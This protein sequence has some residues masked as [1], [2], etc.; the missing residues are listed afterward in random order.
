ML[1]YKVLPQY[2][3]FK[4]PDDGIYIKHE[5][6][7]ANEIA[8]QKLNVKFMKIIEISKREI[9]WFFGVRKQKN[10]RFYD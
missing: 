1:Y 7:T 5:L 9:Y 8:R 2:D 6:Y 10:R 4:K 3:Q